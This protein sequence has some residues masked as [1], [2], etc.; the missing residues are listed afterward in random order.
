MIWLIQF[1]GLE[2]FD[3]EDLC[4]IYYTENDCGSNKRKFV[5]QEIYDIEVTE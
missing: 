5:G 1:Y 2:D 3:H 4:N